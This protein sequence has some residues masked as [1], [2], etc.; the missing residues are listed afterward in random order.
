MIKPFIYLASP[1]SDDNPD[2]MHQ[3]Y[4][5]TCKFVAQALKDNKVI[6]SPIVN[7]HLLAVE[8][9]L[10]SEF[11]FWKNYNEKILSKADMLY[12]LTLD[13]YK[14]SVGIKGEIDYAQKNG[15][16]IIYV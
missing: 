16:P 2:V 15:I 4:L 10:P 3:R 13:G 6:F 1:Y 9:G 7:T 11:K 12:V 14:E 8:E 5:D